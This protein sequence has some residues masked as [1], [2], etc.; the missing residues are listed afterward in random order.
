MGSRQPRHLAIAC[1]QWILFLRDLSRRG[2]QKR[3]WQQAE[4]AIGNKDEVLRGFPAVFD[5]FQKRRIKLVSKFQI[6]W[7][8]VRDHRSLRLQRLAK[9]SNFT[10]NFTA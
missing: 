10:F 5:R 4:R 9:L 3:K 8:N 2:R 1:E 6:E 7:R